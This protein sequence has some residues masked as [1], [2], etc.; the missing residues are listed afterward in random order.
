[1]V[2]RALGPSLSGFGLSGVLSDPVLRVY[3]SSRTLIASNDNWQSDPNHF[4]VE[5]NGLA[6]ANPLESAVA[7]TLAPGAYTVI[8][9]GKDATPGIG[10][11]ELYDLSPLSNS[12]LRNMSTRGSVGTG[13]NV[14]ISGFIVG[15]VDSATVVVRALGPTLGFSYGVSGALSDPTL[16]IY[17]STGS[18]IASNDNW[19]DNIN[20][21]D[22]Q[23]NALSPKDQR[24]SALVLHLPPGAYTAIVRGANGATGN[25]LAEVYNL[26]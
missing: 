18:V 9:T 11:V 15:D 1:M 21:I 20:W 24:E 7:Q 22:V 3:N 5:S 19:L 2:L 8:V 12:K 26:H 14:L 16:T 25:A 13:D 6:P 23:K 4:V 17:D 10:L